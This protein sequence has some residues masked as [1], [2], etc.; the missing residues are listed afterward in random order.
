MTTFILAARPL[1]IDPHRRKMESY[2]DM[3]DSLETEE[4]E[5]IN[6][7]GQSSSINCFGYCYCHSSGLWPDEVAFR[8]CVTNNSTDELRIGD[9]TTAYYE[10]DCLLEF[11]N[12]IGCRTDSSYKIQTTKKFSHKIG[13]NE[14]VYIP[15]YWLNLIGPNE[16]EEYLEN[17]PNLVLK[18][19]FH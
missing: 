11:P 13:P 3:W 4:Q 16:A 6:Q 10:N 19:I 1:Q 5:H 14:S 15:F 9:I 8:F 12:I 17:H 18:I 2:T 7:A